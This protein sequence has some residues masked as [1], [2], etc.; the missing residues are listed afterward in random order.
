MDEAYAVSEIDA[1]NGG[2]KR[3]LSAICFNGMTWAAATLTM[4]V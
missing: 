3:S 4:P 1:W 2:L